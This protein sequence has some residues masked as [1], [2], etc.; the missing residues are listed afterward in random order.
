LRDLL[1]AYALVALVAGEPAAAEV[2]LIL[3]RRRAAIAAPNLAEALDVLGRVGGLPD[4]RVQSVIEPLL[5]SA[6][7]IIPMDQTMAWRAARLRRE[8]YHRRRSLISLAD[9]ACLAASTTGDVL[10]T[11]DLP[12]SRV[13]EAE[14]IEVVL[15]PR[16]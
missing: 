3:R 13:A 15:L 4:E 6:V 16:S 14:D 7:E 8:H 12:L 9:C 2:E 10:V 11:G 5:A 1:D